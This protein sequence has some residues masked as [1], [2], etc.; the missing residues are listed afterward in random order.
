MKELFD[1]LKIFLI[2]SLIT[3]VIYPLTVT[4]LAQSFFHDKANGSL[5]V[6][7]NGKI[8]GSKLLGQSFSDPKYFTG[9]Q[10]A[11]TPAYNAAASS[12]SN[13]GPLSEKLKANL[14]QSEHDL[15]QKGIQNPDILLLTTSAS[16][17]DPDISPAAAKCQASSIAKARQVPV[18]TVLDLVDKHTT[19]R[20][21]GFL[22]EEVVNVLLLNL[23]LEKNQNK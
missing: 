10:S 22:G 14:E 12:G 20:Q 7:Q 18:Q 19:K 1:S 6:N 23:D 13:L 2:L 16:G 4:G 11:T 8:I 17:L 9:R 3:G 21:F 5:V 15:K